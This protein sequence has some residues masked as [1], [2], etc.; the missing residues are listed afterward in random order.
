M[1]NRV[2]SRFAAMNP[3]SS[4]SFVNIFFQSAPA[5]RVP[6]KLDKSFQH[7]FLYF[8]MPRGAHTY[9]SSASGA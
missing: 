3:N 6:Y 5:L 9:C 8:A 4:N 7:S 1:A 2:S